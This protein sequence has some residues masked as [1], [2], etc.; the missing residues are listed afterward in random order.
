MWPPWW[1]RTVARGKTKPRSARTGKRGKSGGWRRVAIGLGIL[2][3]LLL[4]PAGQLAWSWWKLQQPYKGYAEP[5]KLVTVKPGTAA[6]QVLLNLEKE[7]VLADGKLART[8]LIYFLG[9]PKI[10]AGEYL[11]RGH[12]TTSQVL[13]MLV[14]GQVV[15]R[16]VTIVEGLTLEEIADQLAGL[17]R[18][19]VFLDLMRSPRLISDFDPDAPDLEGYLFPETYNFASGT[20]EREIVEAFVHT[21]RRRFERD[22]R[23]LLANGPP[24]RSVRQV[25]TLASIVEKEAKIPSERPLIAAVYRNRL[26]KGIGLAADPTVI[27]ALKRLG[28]WHGNLRREDL[29]MDSPYNT[30]RWA[31]LPPGPICSPGLAS[32]VAAA[33]PADV[34]YLYFVGRND[35]TH[36][37]AETLAEHNR[38]VEIWQRQYWRNRWAAERRQRGG[39]R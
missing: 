15:S 4:V 16:F 12:L 8:Y 37:F 29:R 5:E 3:L 20:S 33:Q 24:G 13:R 35:G 32:L 1:R 14:R 31:G 7:G 36:V 10:Q 38:N 19:E 27:Y 26:A 39:G 18:R 34:P 21:F 22:V 28:R 2:L 11:F 9:D 17:G 6:S 30:Y 23:P 25:V